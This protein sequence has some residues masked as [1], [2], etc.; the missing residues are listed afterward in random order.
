MDAEQM[1][2]ELLKLAA[3]ARELEIK[4]FWQRS[5]F[6][7]GFIAATAYAYGAVAKW[8]DHS[9]FLESLLAHFGLFSSFCWCYVN[10]GSKYW[11]ESWEKK[12]KDL[13]RAP[14]IKDR[15]EALLQKEDKRR[16]LFSGF[17]AVERKPF[18]AAKYSVT[19]ITVFLSEVVIV[20]WGAIVLRSYVV[21]FGVS[22]PQD[23]TKWI[24]LMGSLM[25]SVVTLLLIWALIHFC[26]TTDRSDR[27]PN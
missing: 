18:G 2:L 27:N 17:E 4:N 1:D 25:F 21:C 6:F 20:S 10:K 24:C 23:C 13:E 7:W 15:I 16:W 3:D 26:R 12:L 5:L 9:C 11:Y 14:G 22:V 19:K 8:N